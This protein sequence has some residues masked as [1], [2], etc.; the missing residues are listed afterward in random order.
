VIVRRRFADVIARQL[1][2][3]TTDERPLIADVGE[4][5]AAYDRAARDDAE[6]AYG[7]YV[8]AVDAVRDALAEARG[9]F[10]ATLDGDAAEEY[11][12]AF[13][14]AARKRWRWLA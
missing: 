14:R 6:Q 7:D 1:D 8:D 4:T 10:A 2:L 11:E 12:A 3:F 5:K 13:E 9:R